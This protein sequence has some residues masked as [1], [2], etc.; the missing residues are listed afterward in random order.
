LRRHACISLQENAEDV[1]MWRL[2]APGSDGYASIRI[3]PQL[4]SNDGRVVKQWALKGHGI[5]VRSEW[6]VAQ[7]LRGGTL[8]RILPDHDLPSADILALLGSE[9]RQR[10]ART[11]RFLDLLKQAL[12]SRPWRNPELPLR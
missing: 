11:M 10:S 12:A 2:R 8:V 5:M 9:Q 6:D 4:T 1:T 7:E 3:R